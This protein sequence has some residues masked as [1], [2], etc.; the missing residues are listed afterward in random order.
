MAFE[1]DSKMLEKKNPFTLGCRVETFG[2]GKCIIPTLCILLLWLISL[3]GAEITALTFLTGVALLVTV[4]Q[5]LSFF[6]LPFHV[7]WHVIKVPWYIIHRSMYNGSLCPNLLLVLV[8][9]FCFIYFLYLFVLL[10]AYES[11]FLH[12]NVL[13]MEELQG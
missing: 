2:L 5:L 12:F 3:S 13:G 4:P 7:C 8:F 11:S 6:L 1:S 9:L 10:V